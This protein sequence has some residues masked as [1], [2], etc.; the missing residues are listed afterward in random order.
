MSKEKTMLEKSMTFA[1]ELVDYV[2][3]LD[4]SNP[5][6]GYFANLCTSAAAMAVDYLNA[7]ENCIKVDSTTK[8][9]KE[10]GKEN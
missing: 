7:A 5:R 4:S 6:V 9:V 2:S 1:K 3:K 8:K 10:D